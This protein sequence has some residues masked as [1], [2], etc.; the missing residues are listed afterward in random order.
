MYFSLTTDT[1]PCNIDLRY[2]ILLLVAA[3]MTAGA[4]GIVFRK[5][6]YYMKGKNVEGQLE[7]YD[8]VWIPAFFHVPW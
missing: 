6:S 1:M 8:K 7:L 5:V 4:L 3:M 2:R